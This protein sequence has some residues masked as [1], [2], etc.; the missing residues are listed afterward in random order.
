MANKELSEFYQKL[1]GHI[2]KEVELS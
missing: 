1:L 2:V